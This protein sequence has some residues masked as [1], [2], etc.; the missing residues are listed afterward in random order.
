MKT[1][2][3]KDGKAVVEDGTDL[4]QV[5]PKKKIPALKLPDGDI[6]TEGPVI[7]QY[8]ADQVRYNF[9]VKL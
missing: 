1:V 9:Q 8:I 3:F 2:N 5:N 6:L 4:E 7:S